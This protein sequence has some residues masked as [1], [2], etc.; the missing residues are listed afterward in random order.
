MTKYP[1]DPDADD[2]DVRRMQEA[3]VADVEQ[4][5]AAGAAVVVMD[6]QPCPREVAARIVSEIQRCWSEHRSVDFAAR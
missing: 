2:E 1:Y 3:R 5:L 4:Q 6:G